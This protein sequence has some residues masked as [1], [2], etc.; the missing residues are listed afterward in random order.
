MRNAVCLTRWR[1]GNRHFL[2]YFTLPTSCFLLHCS[3][4]YDD[5]NL[6]EIPFVSRGGAEGA[7][8]IYTEFY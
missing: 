1:G 4:P 2:L 8:V 7:E 5:A 6:G 3:L